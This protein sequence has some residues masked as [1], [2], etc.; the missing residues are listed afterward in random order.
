M[1]STNEESLLIQNANTYISLYHEHSLTS[2]IV[3]TPH[4]IYFALYAP[5][6]VVSLIYEYVKANE[7]S[8]SAHSSA[9]VIAIA[10]HGVANNLITLNCT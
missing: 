2:H 8:G 1:Y 5:G 7:G 10:E 3:D 6:L 4:H 9:T